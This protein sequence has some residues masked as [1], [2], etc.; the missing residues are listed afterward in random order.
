MLRAREAGMR[1]RLA[2]QG[3]AARLRA[4]S[5]LSDTKGGDTMTDWERKLAPEADGHMI[6]QRRAQAG[7]R[8][9]G[10]GRIPPPHSAAL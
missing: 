3:A 6:R 5:L 2:A 8:A 7:L 4:A 9:G 10:G 1:S